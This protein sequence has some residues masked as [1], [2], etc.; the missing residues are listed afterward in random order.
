MRRL[1]LLVFALLA[2]PLPAAAQTVKLGAVVPLTGRLKTS[3]S[4]CSSRNGIAHPPNLS[5]PSSA[6]MRWPKNA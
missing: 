1:A 6:S 5:K 2:L 4:P 3:S